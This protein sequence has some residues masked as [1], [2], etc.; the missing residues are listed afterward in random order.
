MLSDNWNIPLDINGKATGSYTQPPYCECIQLCQFGN[1]G[2][3]DMMVF[4]VRSQRSTAVTAAKCVSVP[5]GYVLLNMSLPVCPITDYFD[6]RTNSP[7]QNDAAFYLNMW[8]CIQTGIKMQRCC[9]TDQ[10]PSRL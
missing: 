6:S 9:Q 1:V 8:H 7:P 10:D 5:Q 4:W 2:M 3:L